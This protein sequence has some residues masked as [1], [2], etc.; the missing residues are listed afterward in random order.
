M[1]RARTRAEAMG[2]LSLRVGCHVLDQMPPK[3]AL[4]LIGCDPQVVDLGDHEVITL[5]ICERHPKVRDGPAPR[6][7]HDLRQCPRIVQAPC[8]RR[9][10]HLGLARPEPLVLK[11]PVWS[12][13]VGAGGAGVVDLAV[14]VQEKASVALDLDSPIRHRYAPPEPG[15]REWRF[16]YLLE[17]YQ[18]GR[19]VQAAVSTGV[20]PAVRFRDTTAPIAGPER[21]A[22]PRVWNPA[23]A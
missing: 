8:Q 16:P 18:R 4:T 3:P 17:V 15:C 5:D 7:L 11:R 21:R 14:R 1:V 22:P 20:L 9:K 6:V 19:A 2:A 13:A 12:S 23:A 10:K